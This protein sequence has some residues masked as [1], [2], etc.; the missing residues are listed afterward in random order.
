MDQLSGRSGGCDCEIVIVSEHLLHIESHH[1]INVQPHSHS[2]LSGIC[3]LGD[4]TS[5]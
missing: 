4:P 5:D 1:I 3:I 2:S